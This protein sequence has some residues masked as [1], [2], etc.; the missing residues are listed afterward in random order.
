[1]PSC[2]KRPGRLELSQKLA[3]PPAAAHAHGNS[4]ISS[5]HCSSKQASYTALIVVV[6]DFQ[7]ILLITVTARNPDSNN[8]DIDAGKAFSWEHAGQFMSVQS[9]LFTVLQ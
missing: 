8:S 7:V 3:E 6:A 4:W 9:H 5:Q 2:D 1:M